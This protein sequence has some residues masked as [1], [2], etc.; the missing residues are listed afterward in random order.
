MFKLIK[1]AF[2]AA[3][4]YAL[5]ELYQ[6]MKQQPGGGGGGAMRSRS[7]GARQGG[8]AMTGPGEGM[9]D[10]ASDSEGGE[11]PTR[12]GRGVIRATS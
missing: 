7:F 6:G 10:T 9:T 2:Y 8:G 5:Y 4:G 3:I 1:L 12:V 11:M